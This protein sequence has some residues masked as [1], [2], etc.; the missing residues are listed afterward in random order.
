MYSIVCLHPFVLFLEGEKCVRIWTFLTYC[1][2]CP[3][4]FV[5]RKPNWCNID[6]KLL[7]FS[8]F[9]NTSN[10]FTNTT[11][12]CARAPA[13]LCNGL[14]V[15][16]FARG[17]MCVPRREAGDVWCLPPVWNLRAVILF[18]FT[19]SSLVLLPSP[20]AFS[21]W[22]FSASWSILLNVFQKIL[23]I[24]FVKR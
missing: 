14:Y 11:F 9:F 4:E 18:H 19:I 8:F 15:Y 5:S 13:R 23:P 20:I 7:F 1:H 24:F 10:L 6:K 21:V 17:R 2:Q 3:E 22:T 12:L 16:M